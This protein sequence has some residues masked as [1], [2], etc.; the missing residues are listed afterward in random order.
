M[1]LQKLSLSNFQGIKSLELVFDSKNANIH[2]TN[3][4]GKTT[5][6]NAITWLLFDRC[7]N[8]ESGFSPKPHDA[9]G[10]DLHNLTSRVEGTFTLTDG[11][12]ITLCKEYYE[13]WQKKRGS[14]TA[15]FSGNTTDYYIDGVPAKMKEY[16][17]KINEMCPPELVKVLTNPL[18]FSSVLP[19]QERRKLLLEVCGDIFDIDVINS[20]PELHKLL[21]YLAIPGTEQLHSVDDY[22]KIV[23]A[24]KAKI[25]EQLE[26]LPERI[27]EATKAIPD[28]SGIDVEA[29]KEKIKDLNI[30]KA[31]FANELAVCGESE[32]IA[33]LRRELS[34]IGIKIAD[35]KVE[36]TRSFDGVISSYNAK[37]IELQNE[38]N[39]LAQRENE[40]SRE[41]LRTTSELEY[42]RNRRQNLSDKYQSVSNSTWQGDTVCSACGQAL[43]S[44]RIESAKTAFNTN[45]SNT[46]EQIRSEIEKTCSKPI[47]AELESKLQSISNEL[48]MVHKSIED[49]DKEYAKHVST[50]PSIKPFEKTESYADLVAQKADI[51]SK[52][53]DSLRCVNEAK[54]NINIKISAKQDEIDALQSE[55]YKVDFAK[56]QQQRVD[57]L[58]RKEK[59]LAAEFEKAC[60]GVYLCELFIKTK[61]SALTEKINDKFESVKF[62]LF[63]TQIN[64]GL[65][66]CCEVLVPSKNS[67]D[68]FRSS[69]NS[70]AKINAGLEIID[71]LSRHFG[72]SMPVVIDNAESVVDLKRISAQL[73]RLTVDSNFNELFLETIF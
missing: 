7:Y 30:D 41:Q 45:K 47:I 69:A 46:L 21:E 26:K 58:T 2:G 20:N 16:E 3:A 29:T 13:N 72:Y 8:D 36:Y 6:A 5:V 61:V 17:A 56:S 25:N 65:K 49:I 53:T 22:K 68:D 60:E 35:A 66:E 32:A 48:D 38:K 43:P 39:K 4:T 31:K 15:E 24:N 51:E 59:E 64:G 18:Y 40:L 1:R 9:D 70:A 10:S 34:D 11:R 57:E 63:E 27:D 55:L 19:W 50:M 73:I 52:M 62:R 23:I 12:I 44:D 54:Q 42:T 37:S 67:L 33:H 14:Q 71:T 28:I